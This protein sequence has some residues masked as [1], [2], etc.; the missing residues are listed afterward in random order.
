MEV[1]QKVQS[2]HASG[3]KSRKNVSDGPTLTPTELVS[4]Q[5]FKEI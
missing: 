5:D 4:L 2:I 1:V 3:T